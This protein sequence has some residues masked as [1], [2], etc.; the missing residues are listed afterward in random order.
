M[1]IVMLLIKES[2]RTLV[3]GKLCQLSASLASLQC[4]QYMQMDKAQLPSILPGPS[5]APGLWF[6]PVSTSA[7]L[8]RTH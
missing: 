6:E 2:V 5:P 8:V 3:K 4:G 1:M 7:F